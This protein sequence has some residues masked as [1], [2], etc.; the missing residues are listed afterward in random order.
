MQ[1]NI[2]QAELAL[3]S[4]RQEWHDEIRSRQGAEDQNQEVGAANS[5]KSL[6]T[7]GG[8]PV[9]ED[10]DGNNCVSSAEEEKVKNLCSNLCCRGD[11]EL[12]ARGLPQF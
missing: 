8:R 6:D 2:D 11:H 5:S 12:T 9:Q 10:N 3:A 1:E 7:S 4:F